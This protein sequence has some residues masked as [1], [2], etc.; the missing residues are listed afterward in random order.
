MCLTKE[1]FPEDSHIFGVHVLS[2]FT[3]HSHNMLN[4]CCHNRAA[5]STQ[6]TLPSALA[7]MIIT[8]MQWVVLLSLFQNSSWDPTILASWPAL[9]VNSILLFLL[10]CWF[11]YLNF[12]SSNQQGN[13]CCCVKM[14]RDQWFFL[15]HTR[16][17]QSCLLSSSDKQKLSEI[18]LPI[19]PRRSGILY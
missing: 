13:L 8:H 5:N 12:K 14:P 19:E 9:V 6:Y 7:R 1:D 18:L 3:I 16:E 10:R 4:A 2:Q 11:P 15:H 17:K